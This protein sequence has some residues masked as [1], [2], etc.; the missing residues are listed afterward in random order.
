MSTTIFPGKSFPDI[1][2]AAKNQHPACGME[3]LTVVQGNAECWWAI[4]LTLL[5]WRISRHGL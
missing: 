2:L 4:E 3:S 5:D 1:S